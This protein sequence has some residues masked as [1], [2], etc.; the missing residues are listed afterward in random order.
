MFIGVIPEVP[1]AIKLLFAIM[2]VVFVIVCLFRIVRR[3]LYVLM[4]LGVLT[5]T[6][7]TLFLNW[8]IRR[9]GPT[10]RLYEHADRDGTLY[11]ILGVVVGIVI[12]KASGSLK[13]EHSRFRR[14]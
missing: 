3:R 14:E 4:G 5:M 10:D 11:L 13:W 1:I 8:L 7:L 9:T 2:S 12:V 6:V